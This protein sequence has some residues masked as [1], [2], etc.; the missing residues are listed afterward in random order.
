MWAFHKNRVALG[1]PAFTCSRLLTAPT[2]SHDPQSP[3]LRL[4]GTCC[5]GVD[6]DKTAMRS[7]DQNLGY[8]SVSRKI[9]LRTYIA[10]PHSLQQSK[11]PK[12]IEVLKDSASS[13]SLLSACRCHTI[14]RSAGIPVGRPGHTSMGLYPL[15]EVKVQRQN[16]Q[17]WKC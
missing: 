17:L 2:G 3:R 14:S 9:C 1:M 13:L 8:T 6:T 4:T 10:A 7:I 12:H 15:A 5:L 16:E 11:H